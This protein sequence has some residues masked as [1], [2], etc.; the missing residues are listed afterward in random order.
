MRVSLFIPCYVDQFYP[1]VGLAMAELI[2]SLGHAVDFPAAQTCCGQPAFNAGCVDEARS[3]AERFVACF[4]D[5]D[6]VVVPSGSCAA[7]VKTF[8]GELFAGHSLADAAARL[9][10]RTWELAT[11]LMQKLGVVDFGARFPHRVTYH[12]GCHGLRELGVREAP[13]Q[14]LRAVAGLE[15]VELEPAE[16]CCGF[17]GTFAVKFPQIS[18]AMAEVKCTAIAKTGA[19]YVISGDPSC[20]MHLE[21]YLKRQGSAVRCLHFSEVLTQR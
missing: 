2:E 18:T 17:G 19:E 3:V 14:L 10:G 5:A 21:G 9:G 6:T 13:R 20:L 11:F 16:Q 4:R 12:D 7:M 8:Y 15:L 1:Q